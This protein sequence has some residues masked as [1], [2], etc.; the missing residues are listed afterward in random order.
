MNT[1]ES[2]VSKASSYDDI[3]DYW[4]THDASDYWDE[5]PSTE[6]D[7][8][9]KSRAIYYP[10]DIALAQEMRAIAKRMDISPKDLLEQWVREKLGDATSETSDESVARSSV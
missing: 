4:D 7:M 3:G 6:F 10:V 1:G 2:S 9:V 5:V 8:D